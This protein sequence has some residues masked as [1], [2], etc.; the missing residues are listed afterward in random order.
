MSRLSQLAIGKRSVTLLLAAAL[1]VAGVLAWG[2]L[3]QELLPDVSFP[4]VTVIAPYPGAGAADVTEQVTKPIERAVSGVPGLDQLQSTSANSFTFVV[5]QFSYGANLDEAV[6]MIE[7]N[8][9]TSNLPGGVE[10]TVAAFN[11]NAA[12]ILIASVS[13]Q[14]GTDLEG[15]AKIA[16]TELIPELLSLPGVATADL[17]GGLEDRLVVT[18]DPDRLAE[19]GVSSQQVVGILQANNL[20]LPGGELS[21]D[22]GRSELREIGRASCR[23]R[24]LRLV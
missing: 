5:A 22:G 13:A 19:A 10:P 24:V 11:F 9:R 4:I 21:V 23:E 15:A 3:K 8:I 6:A 14:G 20:T 1:F 7:D 2:S 18:L 12:P 17:A 16:R